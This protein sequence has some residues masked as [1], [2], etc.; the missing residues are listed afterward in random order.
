M[1]LFQ[2]QTATLSKLLFAISGVVELISLMIFYLCTHCIASLVGRFVTSFF[3]ASSY[4]HVFRKLGRR[5]L[6]KIFVSISVNG[7]QYEAIRIRITDN[8]FVA[9]T[10]VFACPY[11]FGTTSVNVVEKRGVSAVIVAGLES[12]SIRG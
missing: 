5:V 12:R 10:S 7:M 1:R 2:E 8:S 11:G 3:F 4:G 6:D 9:R